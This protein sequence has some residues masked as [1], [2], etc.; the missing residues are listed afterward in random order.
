LEKLVYGGDALGRVEGRVALIPF[1]LPGER[2]LAAAEEEKPALV[3]ARAVEVLE[4]AA[5][6]VVPPCS[7]F[8]TC[9]GCHYQHAPYAFQ[10]ETK[11]NILVET[12]RRIGK[13]EPPE[14]IATLAAEPWGY[15]NRAQFHLERRHLGF[16]EARSHKLCAVAACPIASPKLNEVI[17]TLARLLRDPHW[18]NFLRS[19][20]IFTDERS[21]QLNALDTDR[22]LARRFF[23]WCGEN[24][25]GLVEGALDYDGRFRV[26]RNAFFQVNRFLVDRLVELALEGVGGD[27]ALDLYSGV[28]LFTLPLARRFKTVTAVESGSAAIRDLQFNAERAGLSNVFAEQNSSE[29]FLEKL[30]AAPD[31]VI[32]D[33][34]RSGVGKHVARRLAELKPRSVVIISCDPTTLARDLASLLAAGYKIDQMTLVDLFPQTYHLETV[35]K[36]TAQ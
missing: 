18:P 3:R 33:P 1:T 30:D 10:L 31:L 22:P 2:V 8:G 25:P 11:R 21:V 13:I 24:I 27:S 36:L 17:T 5:N 20:E 32:L 4:P 26:S 9:G 23:E 29:R 12:L 16:R 14:Q 6:R 28:G 34:P 15:R 7:V 35:V 19:I